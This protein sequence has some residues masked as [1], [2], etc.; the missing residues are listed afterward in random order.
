MNGHQ[1]RLIVLEGCDGV[2]NST[3]ARILARHLRNLDIDCEVHAFPG[4][5]PETLGALVYR[6]HHHPHELGIADVS[7]TA[8]QA[9]H[10]AAHLDAIERMIKPKLAAGI[11]VI[12]DRYWWSTA[13]YGTQR[14]VSM[15]V[16]D[17]LLDAER[18]SWGDML[19]LVIFLVDANHPWRNADDTPTWQVLA[20]HYR[21]LAARER[22]RQ[23][24]V[25]IPND[26]DI[27][28]TAARMASDVLP[29][30]D[31]AKTAPAAHVAGSSAQGAQLDIHF[32][33]GRGRR[34]RATTTVLRHFSGLRP[35]KV[36]DTYWR[37]A[38]ERQEI[39][40]RRLDGVSP[41]WTDDPILQRHRFTNAYRASDRVSQF[42]LR[43]VI[44]AGDQQPAEVFFRTVLF[45]LFN[46]VSTWELLEGEFGPLHTADFV[47]E[48]YAR[49]LAKARSANQPIYSAAYVMPVA[50]GEVGR[51]KHSGHLRLLAKMLAEDFPLRLA[52]AKTLR[53]SFEMLRSYPMMGDFLAFQYVI[54]LNYSNLLN[55]KE[56]DFV[57]AGPGAK[58]GLHKCFHNLNG[59]DGSDVIRL[60]TDKQEQEFRRLGLEFRDLWGRPLQPIDC[61]N[62]FCEVD[63][64]ARVA[65]PDI[66]SAQGRTR[67]KQ[68]FTPAGRPAL[69]WYPPKWGLNRKIGHP[70]VDS[71]APD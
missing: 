47:P 5:Q 7:P 15:P 35:T 29:R 52:E 44:Y 14:R 10:V 55:F 31:V 41:P 20:A 1:G 70:P 61:Q 9:A 21:Q 40:F 6:L 51:P 69:P 22:V 13:V 23:P 59:L 49:V 67:I 32:D 30:L 66:S 4:N 39:F 62:I 42:L 11:N 26:G 19:P 68:R 60:V 43:R 63:K 12:L 28:S 71:N 50:P 56:M 16:L 34:D 8:L 27:D 18:V 3:L 45:R 38:A 58:S 48:R 17:R 46:R 25:V 24:V 64:Y 65:H 37:W 57:V 53:Q 2:G 36:F 33:S 54:D